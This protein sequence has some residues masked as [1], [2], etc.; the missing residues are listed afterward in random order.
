VKSPEA[1]YGNS[2]GSAVGPDG[3]FT[4]KGVRS[5]IAGLWLCSD[6]KGKQFEIVRVERNGV[7]QSETINV[8]AGE[9]VAGL[10]VTVK[11]RSLSG[12]IRGQVKFENGEVPLLSQVWVSLWPLDDN[13]QPKPQSS[14]PTPELDARGHFF[15]EGLPAGAYQLTVYIHAAERT[16]GQISKFTEKTQ[17]VTVTENTVT[18]V[19]LIVKPPPNPK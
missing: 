3:T 11:Y 8:N 14:I 6:N 5:G 12:A 9:Q 2:A 18:E 10:R 15:A 13:L 17:Q 7:P 16:S 4:I 1:P 19:T